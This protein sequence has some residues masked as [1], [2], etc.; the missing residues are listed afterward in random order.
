MR[1]AKSKNKEL[2]IIETLCGKYEGEN[3]LEGFC[4]NTEELCKEKDTGAELGNEF[5]QMCKDDNM[6]I[7]ELTSQDEIE[8]P[9]MNLSDLLSG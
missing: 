4:A 3:V 7:F 8:I 9:H 5:Y 2:T 6:V 1:G